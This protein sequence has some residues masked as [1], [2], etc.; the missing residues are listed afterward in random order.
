M[1]LKDYTD[2]NTQVAL[3]K[4]IRASTSFVNQWVSGKRP[5]PATYCVAI[6]QATKGKVTRQEMRDDWQAIWPELAK[7]RK[8]KTDQAEGV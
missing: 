1:N 5:I 4:A 2:Q 8:A 7:T 3:A 6:E